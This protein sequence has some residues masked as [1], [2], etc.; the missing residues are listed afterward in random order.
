MSGKEKAVI[1]VRDL[2]FSYGGPDVLK[3]ISLDIFP[4]KVHCLMGVNGCGKSTLIDCILGINEPAEGEVL[5]DGTPAGRMKPAELARR[6]SYV[7]QVHDRSFPYL[8]RDIVL[9]GRT[10]WQKGLGSPDERDRER[11]RIELERCGIA[12][13]ADRPYTQLSGGEMQM[14]M[15]ARALAQDAPVIVMDEP[16]AHLDFR[17]ELLFLETVVRLVKE[18]R[19]GVLIATHSPNQAFYFEN[20]GVPVETALMTDHTI[21]AAGAPSEV[22]DEQTLR[23]AY[24]MDVRIA[25]IDL[26]EDGLFRQI[27]PIRAHQKEEER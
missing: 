22:L 16:T 12:H 20:A 25:D 17:N 24:R 27:I 23:A 19:I 26:G 10:A 6:I 3:H 1:S 4:G 7:P 18:R 2:T 15:L 8:V 11:C 9:M 21:R 14:V 5:I 13:L